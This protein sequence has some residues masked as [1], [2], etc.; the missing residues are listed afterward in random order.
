M[1]A[2]VLV[3]VVTLDSDFH[4]NKKFVTKSSL[5]FLNSK[6]KHFL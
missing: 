4:Q 3:E 1:D 5:I 6:S 2:K